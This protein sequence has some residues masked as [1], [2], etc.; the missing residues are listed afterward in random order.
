MNIECSKSFGIGQPTVEAPPLDAVTIGI[1][2][3]RFERKRA[4]ERASGVASLHASFSSAGVARPGS[5][6][7]WG[8][9]SRHYRERQVESRYRTLMGATHGFA[10]VRE[11]Q[12]LKA[13]ATHSA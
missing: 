5:P 13:S 7:G 6:S 11:V 4:V 2:V 9:P 8:M 3:T 12:P 10:T 1:S